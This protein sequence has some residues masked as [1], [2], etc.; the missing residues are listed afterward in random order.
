MITQCIDD[1]LKATLRKIRKT[2]PRKKPVG[3]EKMRNLIGSEQ[4]NGSRVI[5]RVE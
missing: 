2:K 5:V 3:V 1:L 4:V